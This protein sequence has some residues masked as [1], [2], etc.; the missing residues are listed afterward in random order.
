MKQQYKLIA[1]HIESGVRS[2][3]AILNAER[4]GTYRLSPVK[5]IGF[6]PKNFRNILNKWGWTPVKSRDQ[7][8]KIGFIRT[9][10]HPFPRLIPSKSTAC[11]R[12][13]LMAKLTIGEGHTGPMG[14]CAAHGDFV[15][16]T[17]LDVD[18]FQPSSDIVT[19]LME[20]TRM[21]NQ[22]DTI[23]ALLI[24]NRKC[25]S[26]LVSYQPETQYKYLAKP[27][28]SSKV[29]DVETFMETM[30]QHKDFATA[31]TQ[32]PNFRSCFTIKALHSPK[33]YYPSKK[34][35]SMY[36]NDPGNL[37]L[38]C[39]KCNGGLGK[40]AQDPIQWMRQNPLFGADFVNEVSPINQQGIM[41]KTRD[42]RGLA[43][44][45]LTFFSSVIIDLFF[46]MA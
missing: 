41:I 29:A 23:G 22:Q 25:R 31:I 20:L 5:P 38:I 35:V 30:N 2:T 18:H 8:R 46:G 43:E 4:F 28:L 1:M 3:T 45:A 44:S 33:E 21:I 10:Q 14:L 11:A 6:L 7:A 27:A 34:L 15:P 42:G 32:D 24:K 36:Y 39:K 12:V 40:H 26:L 16:T 37:W 9:T 13:S 19:R 17:D